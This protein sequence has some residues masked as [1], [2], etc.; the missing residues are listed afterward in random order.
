M[1]YEVLYAFKVLRHKLFGLVDILT[2][3]SDFNEM[4]FLKNMDDNKR[5][6]FLGEY[7]SELYTNENFKKGEKLYEKDIAELKEKQKGKI[8][9]LWKDLKKKYS[10]ENKQIPISLGKQGENENIH[11]NSK[12]NPTAK[13]K[14][15][16]LKAP[17]A[18]KEKTPKAPK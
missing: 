4:D 15:K 6:K 16:T 12:E 14:I 10:E 3:T 18:P 5:T 9:L 7:V 13:K 1:L 17:K 2:K 8:S 11:F